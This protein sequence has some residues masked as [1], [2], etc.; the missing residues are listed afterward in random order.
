MGDSISGVF[1]VVI[2]AGLLALLT[3]CESVKVTR[4]ENVQAA[5]GQTFTHY[6]TDIESYPVCHGSCSQK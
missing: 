5:D 2:V 3:G 4:G 6:H 1:A